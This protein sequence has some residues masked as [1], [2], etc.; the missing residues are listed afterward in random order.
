MSTGPGCIITAT[1]KSSKTPGVEQ[2][3]FSA[4]EL[5]GGCSK[6]RNR[7]AQLVGDLGQRQG[8]AHCRGGDDVVAA[9]MADFGQR[10][11]LGADADSQLAAAE[12]GAESG[13]QSTG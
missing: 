13:V 6:Q 7:Q 4:A 2:Q 5:L 11:V 10:V 12:V 9:G 3:H 8:G 1:A